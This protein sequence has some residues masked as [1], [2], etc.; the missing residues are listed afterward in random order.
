M[1][2]TRT[3][4]ALGLLLVL[5][6]CAGFGGTDGDSGPNASADVQSPAEDPANGTDSGTDQDANGEEDSED[7]QQTTSLDGPHPYTSEGSPNVSALVGGHLVTLQDEETFTLTDTATLRNAANGSLQ[8][9]VTTEKR[10]DLASEQLLIE[11]WQ[12][13]G[14]GTETKTLGRYQNATTI[15][16][17]DGDS[18]DCGP[19]EFDSGTALGRVVEITT[20][21]SVAA[22]A[23]SANGTTTVDG[24]AV[25]RFSADSIRDDAPEQA[26]TE[27][28][29]NATIE[30]ATLLVAPDGH[31]V[32]YDVS[33]AVD[34]D[35][36]RVAIDRRYQITLTD[37]SSLTPPE[38]VPS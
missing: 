13:E 3:V 7:G 24:Q 10:F 14:S 34:G 19:S 33:Y 30:S 1:T 38:W 21:E 22:P 26:I 15:C 8:L 2:R 35:S 31:V 6:G 4:L 12:T 25:Y 20:L 23:F 17:Q 27:L 18:V 29:Q 28:G 9:E 5:A 16:T 36:G 11:R 37:Q 32:R